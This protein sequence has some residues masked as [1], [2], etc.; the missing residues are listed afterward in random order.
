[1]GLFAFAL[2]QKAAG[3][4]GT[5][6]RVSSILH[7][8]GGE[9]GQCQPIG[10]RKKLWRSPSATLWIV[11][12]G[13]PGAPFTDGTAHELGACNYSINRNSRS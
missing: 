6:L 10:L 1:M 11:L 9:H 7:M 8:P 4:A 3:N 13:R 2:K 12:S 5:L